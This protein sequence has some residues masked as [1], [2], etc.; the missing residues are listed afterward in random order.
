M[1]SLVGAYAASHGPLQPNVAGRIDEDDLVAEFVPTTL[2][3]K[4][5]ID[6]HG[7]RR[8]IARLELFHLPLQAGMNA[9]MC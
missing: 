3:E 2:E 6:Y 1:A 4:C 9:G 5:R 8:R 7:G